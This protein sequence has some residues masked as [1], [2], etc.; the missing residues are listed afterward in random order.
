MAS[1][2]ELEKRIDE[3][4]L[5]LYRCVLVEPRVLAAQLTLC[6]SRRNRIPIGI[7]DVQRIDHIVV[8]LRAF[9]ES[10]VD[11]VRDSVGVGRDIGKARHEIT[12]RTAQRW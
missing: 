1:S 3:L 7:S 11:A 4:R 2:D 10:A 8:G 6:P 9:C 5:A 12:A